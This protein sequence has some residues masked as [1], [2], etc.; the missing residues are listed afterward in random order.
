MRKELKE[1]DII[2]N[3]GLSDIQWSLWERLEN[4]IRWRYT[5][6]KYWFKKKYQTFRYGFPLE[7][8]WDFYSALSRWALPRLKHLQKHKQGI[9]HNLDERQWNEILQKIIW[10]MENHDNSPGPIYPPDYDHRQIVK[11]VGNHGTTFEKLDK[12]QID[13]T[14]CDEHQDKVKHGFELLGMYMLDLWD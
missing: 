9:P 2:E 12:R 8:S 7:E 10:S 5:D 1:G 4:Q 11:K 13:F 3:V 6:L 14:P